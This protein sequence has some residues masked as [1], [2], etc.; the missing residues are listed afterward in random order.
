M[1]IMK[2]VVKEFQKPNVIIVLTDDQ[3]YGDLGCTGNPILKTPGLISFLKK[4]S[5]LRIFM[6]PPCVL[7]QGGS[8]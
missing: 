2:N 7:R 1:N 8:L 4:V 3:G 6:L 5:A